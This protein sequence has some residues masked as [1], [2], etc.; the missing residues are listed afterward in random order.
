LRSRRCGTI[1]HGAVDLDL[2]GHHRKDSPRTT[3]R[4]LVADLVALLTAESS[5]T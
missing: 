5:T 2:N 1:A 3:S 4:Q